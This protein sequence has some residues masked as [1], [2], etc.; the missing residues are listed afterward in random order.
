MFDTHLKTIFADSPFALNKKNL[1]D[2]FN[3]KEIKL[4]KK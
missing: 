1:V 3:D 4:A 2:I